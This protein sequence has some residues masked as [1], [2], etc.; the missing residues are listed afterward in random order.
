MNTGRNHDRRR[1]E[2][3]RDRASVGGARTR[4]LTA[5]ALFFGLV[6]L[7]GC[8]NIITQMEV[9]RASDLQGPTVKIT[10]PSNGSYYTTTVDVTGT[11]ADTGANHSQGEVSSVTYEIVGTTTSGNVTFAKDG[12][13]SF[14]VATGGFSGDIA[15]RVTATDWNKNTGTATLNLKDQRTVAPATP[16]GLK[17]DTSNSSQLT[18][19]WNSVSG[20]P[21]YHLLRADEAD[22]SFVEVYSGSNTS[23]V[24]TTSDPNFPLQDAHTYDYKVTAS[25][26]AGTSTPSSVVS[27][28]FDTSVPTVA[29]TKI[30]SS[31]WGA[32]AYTNDTT[33]SITATASSPGGLTITKVEISFDGGTSW[34]DMTHGTDWTYT[35]TVAMTDG[36]YSVVVRATDDHG[37]SNTDPQT[38]VIDTVAPTISIGSPAANAKI[39]SSSFTVSG[40]VSDNKKLAT[41]QGKWNGGSL[42]DASGYSPTGTSSWSVALTGVADGDSIVLTAKAV[43]AA[44]NTA[45]ITRTIGVD[46]TKPTISISSPASGA[47]FTT[48]DSISVVGSAADTHL[49]RVEYQVD[50][51]TGILTASGTSSWTATVGQLS[52]GQHTIYAHAL[53]TYGNVSTLA[54]RTFSVLGPVSGVTASGPTDAN[55][56]A[57]IG[58]S[59]NP[60][61]SALLPVTYS[62]YRDGGLVASG[63]S[64]TSYTD[65]QANTLPRHNYSYTVRAVKS[66]TA[67]PSSSAATGYR[68]GVYTYERSFGYSTLNG[69]SVTPTGLDVLG[70][71]AFVTATLLSD[72]NI[73]VMYEFDAPTGTLV[74]SGFQQMTSPGDILS[75]L[76]SLYV[77]GT[78]GTVY[79]WEYTSTAPYFAIQKT[80]TGLSSPRGIALDSDSGTLYAYVTEYNAGTVEER[81]YLTGVVQRTL[82]GFYHPTRIAH[83]DYALWII[84]NGG[85]ILKEV[86]LSGTDLHTPSPIS[87]S[88][89]FDVTVDSGGYPV[90]SLGIEDGFE[91]FTSA[92]QSIQTFLSG[93]GAYGS[94]ASYGN[95]L[96]IVSGQQVVVFQLQ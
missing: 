56:T 10:S 24:G 7:A 92:G 63:L 37:K 90:V 73:G 45:S 72:S 69:N 30:D 76:L 86:N 79:Y 12:S 33:P 66:G 59:W 47:V 11:V 51:G 26:Q 94:I 64:S 18:I 53:D 27:V 34:S 74:G 35:K 84:D 88:D 93:S 5:C 23:H 82:T 6:V 91:V 54:S 50:S 41:V 96:Y 65:S 22:G 2:Y 9:A 80:W 58:V 31:P 60:V 83:G 3:R 43:D 87:N 61:P 67:G 20:S 1:D 40:T 46:S 16:T 52:A 75:N 32:T 71:K 70:G 57:T 17:I 68:H 77:V 44:G 78:G 81:N 28:Y 4:V 13:F 39:S 89:G 42:V 85:S 8:K 29:I 14:D 19:S 95:E 49:T 55:N 36:T 38:L 25:N 15:I 21:T 62:V 48:A